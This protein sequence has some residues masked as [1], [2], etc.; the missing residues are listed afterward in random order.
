MLN[1]PLC[2]LIPFYC[3]VVYGVPSKSTGRWDQTMTT[4]FQYFVDRTNLSLHSKVKSK[5][6][7]R[8]VLIV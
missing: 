8:N 4:P 3:S 7:L 5:F 6:V 2:V 1:L